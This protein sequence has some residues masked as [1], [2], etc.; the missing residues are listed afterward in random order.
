MIFYFYLLCFT[1]SVSYSML[2][3]H[4]V[5]VLQFLHLS[6]SLFFFFDGL[7][8]AFIKCSKKAFVYLYI[9]MYNIYILGNISFCL[10]KKI[11]TFLLNLFDLVWIEC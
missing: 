8:Q 10:T 11:M 6:L 4:L 7:S 1:F 2:P 9:N 3:F 5:Y